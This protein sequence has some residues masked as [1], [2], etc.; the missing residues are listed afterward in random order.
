MIRK[1][2]EVIVWVRMPREFNAEKIK[3]LTDPETKCGGNT[4]CICA[5]SFDTD[6]SIVLQGDEEL[7]EMLEKRGF[8][9][10]GTD[11]FGG[12]TCIV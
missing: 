4:I 9:H 3:E 1:E 8:H 12:D 11:C 7:G 6:A 5:A 2:G 10:K